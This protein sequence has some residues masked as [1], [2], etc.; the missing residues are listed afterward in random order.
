MVEIKNMFTVILWSNILKLSSEQSKAFFDYCKLVSNPLMDSE[1]QTVAMGDI[2]EQAVD[3][4]HLSDCLEIVDHFVGAEL[5]D[6]E[7]DRRAYLSEYLQVEVEK[8]MIESGKEEL[9]AKLAAIENNHHLKSQEEN[10]E[11][12]AQEINLNLILEEIAA[13]ELL[14]LIAR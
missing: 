1:K 10:P 5:L 8:L 14:R 11:N 2:W 9:L 4:E 13:E 7:I 6:S 12:H 3:D